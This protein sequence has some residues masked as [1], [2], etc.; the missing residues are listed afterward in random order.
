M[1][2]ANSAQSCIDI[3]EQDSPDYAKI[4]IN[5][6]ELLSGLPLNNFVEIVQELSGY[7][8]SCNIGGE[9]DK[10]LE[11]QRERIRLEMRQNLNFDSF[12]DAYIA[13]NNYFD[14]VR[15]YKG[16]TSLDEVPWVTLDGLS[17][18]GIS[19][20]LSTA[21]SAGILGAEIYSKV[22]ILVHSILLFQLRKADDHCDGTV[23][24]IM[25]NIKKAVDHIGSLIQL[26]STQSGQFSCRLLKDYNLRPGSDDLCYGGECI[27]EPS[28]SGT[29]VFD[30]EVHYKGGKKSAQTKYVP[31]RYPSSYCTGFYRRV[32]PVDSYR[33]QLIGEGRNAFNADFLAKRDLWLNGHSNV[34]D[35]QGIQF[36]YDQFKNIQTELNKIDLEKKCGSTLSPSSSSSPSSSP[37][38]NPTP[39]PTPAPTNF[40]HPSGYRCGWQGFTGARDSSNCAKCCKTPGDYVSCSY[41]EANFASGYC[42]K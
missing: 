12:N 36:F 21:K 8:S 37:T 25:D 28:A 42:C 38:P 13:A 30:V 5:G 20:V 16:D 18:D 2:P 29:I 41:P 23:H 17:N 11:I 7:Y 39:N 24:Q 40:C 19:G 31:C 9:V 6:I 14:L 35:D 4:L 10:K 33:G 1:Q 34:A 15:G 3:P 27:C 26:T 32:C 22:A